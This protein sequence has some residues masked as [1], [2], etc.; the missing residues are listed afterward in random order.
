MKNNPVRTRCFLALTIIT[1]F[2]VLYGQ[3]EYRKAEEL[4]GIEVGTVAS[5]FYGDGSIRFNV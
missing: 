5:P 4:T 2:D 3:M 1:R